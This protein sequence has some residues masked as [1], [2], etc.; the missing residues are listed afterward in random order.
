MPYKFNHDLVCVLM[1]SLD[2]RISAVSSPHQMSCE[3]HCTL[4]EDFCWREKEESF[5]NEFKS[6]S[7]E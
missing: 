6:V 5:N 2:S 1:T 7:F 4:C 3:Y